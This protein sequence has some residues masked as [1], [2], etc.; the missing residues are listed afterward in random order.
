MGMLSNAELQAAPGPVN[1]RSAELFDRASDVLPGGN[2]RTTIFYKPHPAYALRGEGAWLWDVD[3]NRSLDLNNNYTS[4]IHGHCHPDIV[5]EI[6]RQAAELI[7]VSMPTEGEVALA[8]ALRLRSPVL[9]RTRFTNSGSEA[10]MMAI[11]AARAFTG[12]SKIAK[13]EGAYHGSYDAAEVSLS[14]QPVNW[15][16]DVPNRVPYCDGTPS[17]TLDNTV[18]VP[19][20]DV[21]L[22]LAILEE[23]AADLAAVLL[24]P[25]PGRIGLIRA[26][27]A[28]LAAIRAFCDRTGTLL[29]FDEVISFRVAHGGAHTRLGV[30][31]DM[32]TLGKIIGGGLPVGAVCGRE[33]VMTVFEE[34]QGRTQ[35]PHG[36][37]FN[38]NPMTM[39]AGATAMR[40]FDQAACA[41]LDDLSI[42]A[43]DRLMKV[44][45]RRGVEGDV[46]REGSLLKI[47]LSAGPKETYRGAYPDPRQN[48]GEE[49]LFRA[50]LRNGLLIGR[51][52]TAALSTPMTEVEIDYFVQQFEL[53]LIQSIEKSSG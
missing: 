16:Q 42:L 50:L 31:P 39:A 18:V 6:Q 4:L 23:N 21:A 24:D 5:A 34:R 15:G 29:I 46:L 17:A 37:T 9:E 11:K 33:A 22:S 12:R 44:F 35:V 40:L 20:N 8:E 25:I 51:N 1:T 45:Q 19:F 53:A 14:S 13:A 30:A 52:L 48:A 7:A 2:T 36:G 32:V 3:G 41:R 43:Q 28:F 47:S 38:A 49:R 26:Q 27:P 10:V